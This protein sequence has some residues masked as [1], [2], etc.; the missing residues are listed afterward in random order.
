MYFYDMTR[1]DAAVTL[2]GVLKT[3]PAGESDD[4]EALENMDTH[5]VS[6]SNCSFPS[7]LY[8]KVVPRNVL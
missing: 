6:S 2:A 8:F 1:D 7:F 5:V 3:L 4:M